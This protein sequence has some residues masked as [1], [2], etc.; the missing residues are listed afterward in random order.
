MGLASVGQSDSSSEAE[1]NNASSSRVSR[2][3]PTGKQAA[4]Q[5]RTVTKAKQYFTPSSYVLSIYTDSMAG[6]AK[7]P[8][9]DTVARCSLCLD[10]NPR[11]L[12][13]QWRRFGK[14]P[15]IDTQ[16]GFTLKKL[17]KSAELDSCGG[18]QLL[19]K[20]AALITEDVDLTF[21]NAQL[22]FYDEDP[23]IQGL[24][25]RLTTLYPSCASEADWEKA[26]EHPDLTT[27]FLTGPS[28]RTPERAREWRIS[29]P[30]YEIFCDDDK[31]D[32][33]G[34]A[35]LRQ[36]QRLGNTG[37]DEAVAWTKLRLHECVSQH[38]KCKL[39]SCLGLPVLPTRVLDLGDSS[40]G[41]PSLQDPLLLATGGNMRGE[42][43]C[44]SHCWGPPESKPL[45]TRTET[46][47]IFQT[48]GITW[49]DL[50][51]TFQEAVLF[52]RKLGIRYLWI[53]SLCIIQNDAEDW[54]REAGR[55]AT[56][57]E[58]AT[59][60]LA[61]AASFSSQEGLFRKSAP[62]WCLEGATYLRRCPDP[63]FF[64][65][66]Y[67]RNPFFLDRVAPLSRR[68]W[69]LQERLISRRLLHFTP[70]E[71]V[72]ECYADNKTESGYGWVDS[73]VKH[74]LNGF[75]APELADAGSTTQ[76]MVV[77]TETW[78]SLVKDFTH[79]QLTRHEDT[80]PAMA[81]L[82]KKTM[83]LNGYS[84]NDYLAGLWRHTFVEDMMWER[85]PSLGAVDRINKNIPTWSW[86]RDDKPKSFIDQGGESLVQVCDLIEGDC[87]PDAV[88]GSSFLGVRH[89]AHVLLSG[90]LLPARVTSLGIAIDENPRMQYCPSKD[91]DWSSDSS[92]REP[93]KE[94]DRVFAMPLVFRSSFHGAEGYGVDVHALVLRPCPGRQSYCRIGIFWS[95][96]LHLGRQY[97]YILE[98]NDFLLSALEKHTAVGE[99]ILNAETTPSEPITSNISLRNDDEV[100]PLQYRNAENHTLLTMYG[101]KEVR[102][103]QSLKGA[104]S[105]SY[106]EILRGLL[107]T[108]N[109]RIQEWKQLKERG[110]E[111]MHPRSMI[112]LE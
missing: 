31:L 14:L 97:D 6:T 105:K 34:E 53:D 68:A 25:I 38:A 98:G 35:V 62:S 55:M 11:F 102:Q 59:L 8:F 73:T 103:T 80:L 15:P 5:M 60:T 101:P 67:T 96:L 1:R 40:D 26:K 39:S 88:S 85:V 104:D 48:D 43:V 93:V 18:C 51:K 4:I 100:T 109:D 92:G 79:L 89:G 16:Y 57:Y 66:Q 65:H 47:S 90:Y 7:D 74:M 64:E 41:G 78:R 3:G 91:Y 70:L 56:T 58:N 54:F 46:M 52:T 106:I 22:E 76:E 81:G 108:E 30:I 77:S 107:R 27:D 112:R 71:L 50:P 24:C 111:Q 20:A 95:T 84:E 82:A 29:S 42:Y 23:G 44:L 110:L 72:F 33:I 12:R 19:S 86:A 87:A 28:K 10:L 94:G 63:A 21:A 2:S 37:S 99:S 32:P 17:A 61:A 49:S 45:D 36:T 13:R 9:L 69:V 75:N 83:A